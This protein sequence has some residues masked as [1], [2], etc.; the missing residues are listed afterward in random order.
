MMLEEHSGVLFF[1]FRKCGSHANYLESRSAKEGE[2]KLL[3][4]PASAD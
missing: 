4:Q 2:K 3:S 1:L